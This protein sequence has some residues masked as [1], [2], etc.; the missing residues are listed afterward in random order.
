MQFLG[1]QDRNKEEPEF[2]LHFHMLA[3]LAFAP[4]NNVTQ[5][6]NQLCHSI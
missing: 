5:Y 6:L 2:A 4:E 1:L 3:A